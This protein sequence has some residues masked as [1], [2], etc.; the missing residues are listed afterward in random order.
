MCANVRLRA[1]ALVIGADTFFTSRSRQL[2]KLTVDHAVPAIY[3][4]R[5]FTTAGGL[6][7]YGT[8]EKE[9]YRVVG[10]Y[11]GKVLKGEKPADLPVVQST[12]VEMI[13]NLK[14]AKALGVNVPLPADRSCRRGDRIKTMSAIGTKR[15]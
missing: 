2:A 12:K 10:T 3:E 4:F 9:Y 14:T 6:M 15:T 1:S 8:D 11:T 7:S 5:E 13:L